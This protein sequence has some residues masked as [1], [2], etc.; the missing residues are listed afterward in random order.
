MWPPP[1][2]L[3]HHHPILSHHPSTSLPP[4]LCCC[5]LCASLEPAG[6]LCFSCWHMA[7]QTSTANDFYDCPQLL[8]N[9]NT[10]RRSTR[11]LARA[12]RVVQLVTMKIAWLKYAF[13]FLDPN[14]SYKMSACLSLSFHILSLSFHILFSW[15]QET[16]TKEAYKGR[17]FFL[18]EC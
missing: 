17:I 5:Y 2:L 6:G 9:S 14:S 1:S 16:S 7:S 12:G 10:S 18:L 8:Y 13:Q 11:L 15:K 3:P 4:Y